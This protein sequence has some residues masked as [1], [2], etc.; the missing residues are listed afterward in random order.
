MKIKI[1]GITQEKEIP[2]LNAL[3][4]DYVGLVFAKSKR[5]I[6]KEKAKELMK[7]L[8]PIIQVVGVFMDQPLEEVLQIASYCHLN[9]IQLHGK[10]SPAYCSQLPYPIWKTMSMKEKQETENLQQRLNSLY[11]PYIQGIVLDGPKGGSGVPFPW[12]WV[13]EK[14]WN[15]PLILAGGL[16]SSNVKEAI[17]IVSPQV[18]DVSSGVEEQGLKSPRKIQQFVKEIRYG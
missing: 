15:Q 11:A 4:I 5:Q 9:I 3:Q 14:T 10:E 6:Q 2:I 13:G 17:Q 8:D 12:H 7:K 18:V 16:T 1:C